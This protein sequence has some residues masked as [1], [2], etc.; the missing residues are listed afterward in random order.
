MDELLQALSEFGTFIG[1]KFDA[2]INKE[3]ISPSSIQ[4]IDE[5]LRTIANK[6]TVE[7]KFPEVQ[8]IA[9][10]GVS[11]VT[12]KGD[13]GEKGEPG[14]DS[15]TPG[16][17]G[18]PG[19]DGKPGEK[20]E[21]GSPGDPGKPGK[22]GEPGPQGKPGKDGK[23][24]SPDTGEQIVDKINSDKSGKKIKVE[25]LDGYD[26]FDSRLKTAEAN[27]I[28]KY[29][30]DTVYMADLSSQT[31]GTTKVFTLPIN[32]SKVTFV[33]GSDFPTILFSGNGFTRSGAII[34]LTTATAP[35]SG[36]QLGCMYAI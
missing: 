6:E 29:A 1:K 2:L 16:P 17:Q 20:G 32:P 28:L 14:A 25:H 12:I 30:G 18:K 26:N 15:I 35:S 11:V 9:I 22:D 23:D 3:I 5:S 33:V 8:K 24:G 13:P 34:T 36:S 7:T 21:P 27:F 10:E 4:R 19:K 31:N